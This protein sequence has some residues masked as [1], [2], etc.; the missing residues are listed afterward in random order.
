M[1]VRLEIEYDGT[2]FAGWQRQPHKPTVQAHIEDT[3]ASVVGQRTV[4]YGASRTDSGVHALGQVA[5]FFVEGPYPAP[6]WRKILNHHL[7]REIRIVDAREVP[8]TFHAQKHAVS[9]IYEYR[10]L[11]RNVAS[12]LDRKLL[13][14]PKVC[15]WDRVRRAMP[16]FLGHHD[17]KSFQAA[18]SEVRTTDREILSF[19][20]ETEMPG[21]FVFRIEGTGF[22]KQMVRSVVGTLL[23]IGEG[24]R[25]PDSIP[26]ILAARDRR[27]AGHTVG[28]EGLCLV[29]IR[30][31]GHA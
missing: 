13:F 8:L 15:D 30:Y 21:L 19:T 11:N 28:P 10:V 16:Y 20:L 5:N 12:A 26:A 14:Y 6:T 22:L 18:K 9:K 31:G 3:I 23:E 27:A 17:F 24:K 25:D 4:V 29:R 7:P 1:N 2:G